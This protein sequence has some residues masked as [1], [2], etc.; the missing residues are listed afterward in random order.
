MLHQQNAVAGSASVI[1]ATAQGQK[2]TVGPVA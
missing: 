2:H 1:E